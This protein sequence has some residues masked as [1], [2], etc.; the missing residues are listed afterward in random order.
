MATGTVAVS[1]ATFDCIFLTG[2]VAVLIA[3]IT[4][5]PDGPSGRQA[6]VR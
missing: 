4:G 3:G 2:V 1:T 6:R 5:G